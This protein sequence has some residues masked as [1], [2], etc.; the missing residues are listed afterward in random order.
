L[1]GEHDLVY[2]DPPYAPPRDD[3][4]YI[5]RYHFLEGLSA[6]WHGQD[7]MY[8]T[9]TKK[10]AKK[11]TL[12][13]YKHT[14]TEAIRQAVKQFRDSII[15]LS[16]SSNAVPDAMT[17]E[18]LLRDVKDSVEVR[19]VDHRYSFGTHTAARRREVSEYIFIGR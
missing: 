14:V 4:C 1:S 9:K 11:Y 12:F 13:S 19:E 15:V 6:Y 17:I 8:H 7:I 2:L 18:M 3:N 10:L 16:Y 5:K